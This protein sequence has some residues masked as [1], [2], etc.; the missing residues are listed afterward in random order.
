MNYIQLY[1]D[2]RLT[3]NSLK[4]IPALKH[5]QFPRCKYSHHVQFS[6]TNVMSLNSS[7]EGDA[8]GHP[9]KQAIGSQLQHTTDFS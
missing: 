7:L 3:A 2:Q 1:A 9:G 5:F 8:R 4:K 6:A